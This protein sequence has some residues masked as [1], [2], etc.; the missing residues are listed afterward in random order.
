MPTAPMPS[1]ALLVFL[2]GSGSSG[3]ELRTFLDAAPL[4]ACDRSF[5]RALREDLRCDLLCPTAEQRPY[6]PSLGM[7]SNVW[8]DRSS[9]FLQRGIADDTE[10]EQGVAASVAQ[11]TA[12][13]TANEGK[14]DHLFVG[15][16]SMGGGLCLH[17]L[18]NEQLPSKVRGVFTIGSFVVESS[19]ALSA[20]YSERAKALPLLMMHGEDDSLIRLDWG[21][22]TALSL[23][24]QG[25]DV[26]FEAQP[27][28]DHVLHE[29]QLASALEWMYEVLLAA[30]PAAALPAGPDSDAK[31]AGRAAAAEI[32]H[33][34]EPLGGDRVRVSYAL[35]Q[36]LHG[37]C[38]A[39]PVLACGGQF[40]LRSALDGRALET[41]F[42]SANPESTAEEIKK[43]IVFRITNDAIQNPCNTS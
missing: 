21:K 17:L 14:Y 32:Q 5:S 16:F 28:A 11:I 41:E 43:R 19:R 6:T 7:P 3:P 9:H 2:H 20:R 34:L 27:R 42:S 31:E 35:P 37:V 22:Q 12:I 30:A 1:S 15:G 40:E 38:S 18:R 23:H 10:D 4:D 29:E 8:F 24:M 36:H 26:R 25:L 33:N 13:L 39:R